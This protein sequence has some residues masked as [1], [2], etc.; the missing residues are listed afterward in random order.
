MLGGVDVVAFRPALFASRR[1]IAA[2]LR[3]D[4]IGAEDFSLAF[5]GVAFE[6]GAASTFVAL[7]LL[8]P[9]PLSPRAARL[10]ARLAIASGDLK[11]AFAFCNSFRRPPPLLFDLTSSPMIVLNRQTHYGYS[12]VCRRSGDLEKSESSFCGGSKNLDRENAAFLVLRW[13]FPKQLP[14]KAE[15]H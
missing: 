3:E 10:A 9:A 11:P 13:F 12:I 5:A 4:L 1:A 7:A 8:P 14:R 6:A 15:K 2:G